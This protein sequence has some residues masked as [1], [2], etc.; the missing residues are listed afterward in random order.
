MRHELP[1]W[2]LRQKN[3]ST[4]TQEDEGISRMIVNSRSAQATFHAIFTSFQ[5]HEIFKQAVFK[6]AKDV[7]KTIKIEKIPD[8][9]RRNH[10]I[11]KNLEVASWSKQLQVKTWGRLPIISINIFTGH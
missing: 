8:A 1:T 5:R 7:I 10:I 11:Q 3:N 4:K 9:P 6:Q 2:A